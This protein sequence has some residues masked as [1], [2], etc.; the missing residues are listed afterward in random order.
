[1]LENELP[2]LEYFPI[3]CKSRFKRNNQ[4]LNLKFSF[5][6][7]HNRRPSSTNSHSN[8]GMLP[9]KAMIKETERYRREQ[10]V[11]ETKA[12]LVKALSKVDEKIDQVEKEIKAAL[13]K[14]ERL[15]RE[16]REHKHVGKSEER[17]DYIEEID[18]EPWQEI[19]AKNR[20]QVALTHKKFDSIHLLKTENGVVRKDIFP[21]YNQALDSENIRKLQVEMAEF[22]PKLLAYV[23]HK[24]KLAF[25]REGVLSKKYDQDL[26]KWNERVEKW[27]RSPKKRIRDAKSREVFERMFPELK[28]HRENQERLKRTANREH[29]RSEAELKGRVLKILRI[30]IQ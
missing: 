3:T 26:K 27:N 4:N 23:A 9:M 1:M 8:T 7:G 15:E 28:R 11:E 30:L 18:L 5:R 14:K 22:R 6:E 20:R 2:R 24:K 16:E 25:V 17:D 21:Q 12:N 19:Y 29:T 10:S 13:R